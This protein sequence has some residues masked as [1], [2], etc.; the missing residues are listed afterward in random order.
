MTTRN[1][2]PAYKWFWFLHWQFSYGAGP[3]RADHNPPSQVKQSSLIAHTPQYFNA[4]ICD[5]IGI[6]SQGLGE[7]T[8][9]DAPSRVPWSVHNASDF[10]TNP[11]NHSRGI[12]RPPNLGVAYHCMRTAYRDCSSTCTDCLCQS[13]WHAAGPKWLPF[14]CSFDSCNHNPA[15]AISALHKSFQW[16]ELLFSDHLKFMECNKKCLS[17]VASR[18]DCLIWKM[19]AEKGLLPHMQVISSFS[20][21]QW[22]M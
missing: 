18:K 22:E 7:E 5:R 4:N 10:L 19:D 1:K 20:F 15:V 6:V 17:F 21:G 16:N 2:N 13:Q 11:H 12:K 9:D 3:S 14:H 8:E